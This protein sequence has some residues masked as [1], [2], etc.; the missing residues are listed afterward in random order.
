MLVSQS[1]CYFTSLKN[2]KIIKL[3]NSIHSIRWKSVKDARLLDSAIQCSSPRC[4]NIS[5]CTVHGA[6]FILH[7]Y[8]YIYI[9]GIRQAAYMLLNIDW[10]SFCI[11]HLASQFIYMKERWYWDSIDIIYGLVRSGNNLNGIYFRATKM[12]AP[13]TYV[14]GWYQATYYRFTVIMTSVYMLFMK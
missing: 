7:I 10:Q 8:I 2:E 1:Q 13:Y 11:L 12:C 9:I 4:S 5:W 14:Y 3:N 6:L